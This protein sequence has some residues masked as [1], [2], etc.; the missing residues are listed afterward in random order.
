MRETVSR[1]CQRKCSEITRSEI[2]IMIVGMRA[3]SLESCPTLL[4]SMN[5]NPP[6][7]S[8]HAILQARITEWV[9]MPSSQET[10]RPRDRT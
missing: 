5:C 4:D 9:A 6:G 3:L 7:S 8:V 1:K 10:S 2:L